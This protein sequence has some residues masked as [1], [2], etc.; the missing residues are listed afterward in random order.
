MRSACAQLNLLLRIPSKVEESSRTLHHIMISAHEI[1][2]LEGNIIRVS[3]VK[4][5]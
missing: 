5:I 3:Y 4:N 2:K 1:K